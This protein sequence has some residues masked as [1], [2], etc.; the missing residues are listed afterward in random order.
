MRTGVV[1]EMRDVE[2]IACLGVGYRFSRSLAAERKE[3]DG[4]ANRSI[5]SLWLVV[6]IWS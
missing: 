1:V 4:N 3:W 2:G 5:A 6:I